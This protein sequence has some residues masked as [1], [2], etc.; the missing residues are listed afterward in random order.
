MVQL[1]NTLICKIVN[2]ASEK[3]ASG[4]STTKDDKD[5][6]GFGLANLRESLAKYDSV[7]EIEWQQGKFSLSFV[8][9]LKNRS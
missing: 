6:H 7:P 1:D 4:F 2:T 9:P 8:L 3:P 5:N